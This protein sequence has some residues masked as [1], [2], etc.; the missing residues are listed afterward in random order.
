M[1]AM[2]DAIAW[3]HSAHERVCDRIEPWAH[4]TAVRAT[5]FPTYYDFNALRLEGPDPGLDAEQLAAEAERL[6]GDL[7]HRKIEVEDAVAGERLRPGFEALGWRTTR[8]LW[9]AHEGPPPPTSEDLQP[10]DV[11]RDEVRHLRLEWTD[12]WTEEEV[13]EF[14]PV[15]DAVSDLEGE[16]YAA[17]R[18]DDGRP[19]AFSSYSATPHGG[20]VLRVFVTER[21]RGRGIGRAL[22]AWTTGRI[23]AA[24]APLAWITADDEYHA[25]DLYASLGFRAVWTMYEFVRDPQSR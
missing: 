18:G 25:K 6:Q 19:V 15:A 3:R 16:R 7:E 14:I 20:E 23:F 12:H 9:M 11:H 10:E 13:A 5:P 21:R 1:A 22:T 4:G 17:V 24:G 2:S 8:L